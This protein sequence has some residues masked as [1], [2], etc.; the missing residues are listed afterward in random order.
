MAWSWMT[1]QL[2]ESRTTNLSL[3]ELQQNITKLWVPKMDDS[4]YLK[5]WRTEEQ[6]AGGHNQEGG[7]THRVP[8]RGA[9]HPMGPFPGPTLYK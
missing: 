3:Q 6:E 7:L 8:A 2:S 9:V 4:Q 1:V 5:N